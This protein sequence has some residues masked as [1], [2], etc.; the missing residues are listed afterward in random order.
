MAVVNV[1]NDPLSWLGLIFVFLIGKIV[2]PLVLL[3]KQALREKAL[4]SVSDQGSLSPI[5]G[6]MVSLA[7][8]I[9]LP[10]LGKLTKGNSNRLFI[11]GNLWIILAHNSK[12][13]F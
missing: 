6:V 11:W 5:S 3:G 10:Q 8:K 13:G 12:K 2:H 7:L 9:Y 4:R 1:V